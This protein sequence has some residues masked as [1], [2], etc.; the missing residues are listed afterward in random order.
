[1]SNCTS[2]IKAIVPNNKLGRFVGAT[3]VVKPLPQLES[4]HKFPHNQ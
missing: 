2:Y 1:M 3:Q 4:N